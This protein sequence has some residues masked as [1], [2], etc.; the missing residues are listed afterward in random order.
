MA[1]RVKVTVWLDEMTARRLRAFAGWSGR[2]LGDIVG[3]G[4]RAVLADFECGEV[5][6]R[7]RPVIVVDGADGG[8]VVP[9]RARA[10]S[11]ADG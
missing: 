4:V 3:Q 8:G 9:M 7:E 11:A 6:D 2:E 10:R 5:T 1:K